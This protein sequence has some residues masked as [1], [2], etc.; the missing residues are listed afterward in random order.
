MD[1]IGSLGVS[2]STVMDWLQ[3]MGF[4]AEDSK[5][6]ALWQEPKNLCTKEK[7]HRRF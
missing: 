4:I 7:M 2:F 5:F 1:T 3:S 6:L